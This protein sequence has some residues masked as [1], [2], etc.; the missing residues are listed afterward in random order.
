MN[1][2]PRHSLDMTT[3]SFCFAQELNISKTSSRELYDP[4]QNLSNRSS[5]EFPELSTFEEKLKCYGQCVA[6]VGA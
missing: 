1:G 6:I 5:E 3:D 4:R 2:K